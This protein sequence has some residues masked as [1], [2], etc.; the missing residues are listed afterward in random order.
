MTTNT[1][2]FS[3]DIDL[4][5]LGRAFRNNAW[6][7]AA[8]SLA[9]GTGAW[10]H[11]R[12]QPPV[13]VATTDLIA[14]S[15]QASSEL[16]DR[17]GVAAPPLPPG[18]LERV[19]VS[20]VVVAP[21]LLQIR[22]TP[23]IPTEE[24]AE[25]QRAL[26]RELRQKDLQ[27]V[28]LY[29]EV[30]PS[31]AGIY[32]VSAR[33]QSPGTAA[34]LANLAANV[35]LEWDKGRSLENLQASR[36]RFQAQAMQIDEQL[37]RLDLSEPQRQTLREQQ[38]TVQQSLTQIGILEA[39]VNGILSRLS[40]AVPP[41]EPIEPRPMKT[42]ALAAILGL[43]L[44]SLI[45]MVRALTDRAIHT[46]EDLAV[47]GLPTLS[48]L[49]ALP[50]QAIARQGVV[51]E[52]KKAG[53]YEAIGFLRVNTEMSLRSVDRPV[54]MVT[55][56]TPGEGKSSVTAMLAEGFASSGR[57]VLIVD[58]DLRR[59]TQMSVWRQSLAAKGEIHWRQLVGT[60]GVRT[61]QEALKSP[62]NIQVLE[63]DA[64]I[65]LLPAGPG[66]TNSLSLLQQADLP[67]FL[68][69]C[70]AAYDVVLLD[71]GPLLAL[72]DGLIVGAQAD[73]VVVVVGAKTA[74]AQLIK[75]VLSRADASG[76]NVLGFV[77]NRAAQQNGYGYY[78]AY[79]PTGKGAG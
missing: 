70:R 53:M 26:N 16:L 14:T 66:L 46:E 7:I 69:D 58:V 47:F 12:S 8:L 36:I 2:N 78:S 45:T 75:R 65:D 55:S 13:Y 59:G 63:V 28:Q 72:P 10:L 73:G 71:T 79:S 57:R 18:A 21:L 34:S 27:T 48:V 9:L 31:G 6:R 62:D 64:K 37:R 32:T 76:L 17:S 51:S 38:S 33:A 1:S 4:V 29:G 40:L 43:L 52:A 74:Q 35:M 67:Q 3:Q 25:L 49:P 61:T 11:A 56:S 23:D 30:N 42:A 44:A 15:P 20:Q 39:S 5:L 22:N 41:L 60:G 50:S 68:Q 54:I 24:K 77:L 19:L